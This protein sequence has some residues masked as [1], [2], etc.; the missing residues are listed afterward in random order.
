MP[1]SPENKYKLKR[2]FWNKMSVS[3][4]VDVHNIFINIVIILCSIVACA[5]HNR[6]II[7]YTAAIQN[8][9]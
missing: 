2:K 5:S 9:G 8:K 6:R 7:F 4:C 1:I 3:C